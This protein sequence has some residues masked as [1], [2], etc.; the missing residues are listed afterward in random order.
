MPGIFITRGM[1]GSVP[2]FQIRIGEDGS[3]EAD[4]TFHV[5]FDVCPTWI[6]IAMRH[7]NDAVTAKVNRYEVW[8]GTDENAKAQCLEAEFEA[9]M[10]AIMAAAIAWDAF[11]AILRG[12]VPIPD[13][14]AICWQKNRTAR[15]KQVLEIVR[16]GFSLKRSQTAALKTALKQIYSYRDLAVHPAGNI[17]APLLHPELD[18][19]TEWRFVYFRTTNAKEL[20]LSTVE[21][22]WALAHNGKPNYPEIGNYLEILSM[23]LRE[24]F[25][26]GCP[27]R[28]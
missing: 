9:S 13:D 21:I 26:S 10:Q 25:P 1:M 4:A 8:S 7:L 27:E 12:Y 17:E 11:Y 14:M 5:R 22:I 24:I 15:Y 19:G 28:T 2:D 20:V 16:R 3:L 18:V 6:Q 23:R